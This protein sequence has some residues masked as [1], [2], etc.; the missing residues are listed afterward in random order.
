MLKR[1][2]LVLS[3]GCALALV[4]ST[5]RSPSA[6]ADTPSDAGTVADATVDDG[7]AAPAGSGSGSGSAVT[8]AVA[9][10]EPECTY[11]GQPIACTQLAEQFSQHPGDGLSTVTELWKGGGAVPA[12]LLALF[13][14]VFA[15]S[16]KLPWLTEGNRAAYT[17][18]GLGALTI[19]AEPASRGTTPT[20]PMI[21]G[22]IGA[23]LLLF[24]N[25]RKKPATD[26]AS[27]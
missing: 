24:T 7:S 3:F 25:A 16:K 1:A 9:T 4:P 18:A 20:L 26:T 5:A 19:L 13:A 11:K 10:P 27:T 6:W 2:I 8:P 14:L 23:A 17:A 15:A 22:A 12:V 21:I